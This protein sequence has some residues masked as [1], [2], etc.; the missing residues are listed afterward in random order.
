VTAA[1]AA[2]GAGAV[3]GL[4]AFGFQS[5]SPYPTRYPMVYPGYSGEGAAAPTELEQTTPAP[6]VAV[7]PANSSLGGVVVNVPPAARSGGQINQPLPRSCGP[8]CSGPGADASTGC[9]ESDPWAA[10]DSGAR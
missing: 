5:D 3:I 4:F 7:P 8:A 2:V 1:I 10:S 6:N 9:S